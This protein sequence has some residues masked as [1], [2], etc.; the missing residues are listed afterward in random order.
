M[1]RLTGATGSDLEE[2]EERFVV[3][4]PTEIAFL[5][6]QAAQNAQLVTA[7]FDGSADFMLTTILAVLPESAEVVLDIGP[8]AA[9]NRRM[10][11]ARRMLLITSHDQV[12]I[13]FAAARAQEVRYQG[14][15]AFRIP[16]PDWLVR[17]QRR[18]FYRIATPITKPLICTMPL[19]DRGPGAQAETIVLDISC[20]GVALMDNRE[21]PGFKIGDIYEDC[22]IGLTEVGTLA[23]T[24]EVRNAF[25]TPLKNGMSFRRCGCRFRDL[26]VAMEGLVQ[27]Y[28][29]HLERQRNFLSSR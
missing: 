16:M 25:N 12:R 9:A 6:K 5:L 28:I 7:Y 13:K 27:R 23:V 22:R 10:L 2:G 29:M 14:K 11:T 3:H 8:D 20:G 17:A 21:A 19:P 15:P 4:S 18:E 26:T 24:L 1:N